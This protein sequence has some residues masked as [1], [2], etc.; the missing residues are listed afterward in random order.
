MIELYPPT[1]SFTSE[2]YSLDDVSLGAPLP[3]VVKVPV[4]GTYDSLTGDIELELTVTLYPLYFFLFC[5][6]VFYSARAT[7]RYFISHKQ[8]LK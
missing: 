3:E 1:G 5:L 8:F 6:L 7:V 4:V 2:T